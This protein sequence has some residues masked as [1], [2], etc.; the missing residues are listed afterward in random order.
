[1]VIKAI[2]FR[3]IRTFIEFVEVCLQSCIW[4][5]YMLQSSIP[6]HGCH[7]SATQPLPHLSTWRH[8][9][10]TGDSRWVVSKKLQFTVMELYQRLSLSRLRFKLPLM[11]HHKGK[12][13]V[14]A[15]PNLHTICQSK[16]ITIIR[17]L[18]NVAGF[19][20]REELGCS[21]CRYQAGGLLYSRYLL[22]GL[23]ASFICSEMVK[24]G[25]QCSSCR[26]QSGTPT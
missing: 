24:L 14:L 2:C 25:R 23:S 6:T 17:C 26:I 1:M 20:F 11:K 22:P 9:T 8:L 19:L 10:L 12:L 7:P 3:N 4:R 18:L 21:T 13:L 16:E 5:Q 15:P